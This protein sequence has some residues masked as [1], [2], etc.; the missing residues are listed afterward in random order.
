VKSS[1]VN[2][3]VRAATSADFTAKT[4]R[5]WRATTLATSSLAQCESTTVTTLNEVLD[6]VAAEMGNT[7]AVCRKSYVHP[8]VIDLF[9]ADELGPLWRSARTRV[10]GLDDDESRVLSVLRRIA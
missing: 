4:L 1:D 6:D 10:D 2:E 9:R 8:G 7:R 3:Y 5:T